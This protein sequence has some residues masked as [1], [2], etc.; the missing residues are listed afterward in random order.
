MKPN[1]CPLCNSDPHISKSSM[2]REIL[3]M[4]G[5]PDVPPKYIENLNRWE[6]ICIYHWVKKKAEQASEV[7]LEEK[8]G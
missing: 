4:V 6:V 1:P 3:K 8:R 7:P 5:Y 2:Y